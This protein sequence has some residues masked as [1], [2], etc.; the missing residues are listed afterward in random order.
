[1]WE[2][3]YGKLF[4]S[5]MIDEQIVQLRQGMIQD[6][7][8][9]DLIRDLGQVYREEVQEKQAIERI[10]KQLTRYTM[11]VQSTSEQPALP[12]GDGHEILQR[13]KREKSMRQAVKS[14]G[15]M[16]TRRFGFLA[17]VLIAT[18]LVGSVIAL[19]QVVRRGAGEAGSAPPKTNTTLATRQTYPGMY[20]RV[21]NQIIKVDLQTHNVVWR[22]TINSDSNVISISGAPIVVGKSVYFIAMNASYSL[23][24]QTGKLNWQRDFPSGAFQLYMTNGVLYVPTGDND[25]TLYVLNPADGSTKRQ[26]KA[27][28][29]LDGV[30]DGVIYLTT[31][32]KNVSML[33]AI[34]VSDGSRIWQTKFDASQSLNMV[35]MK[36]GT[37][38]ASSYH[39]KDLV[40]G[41]IPPG[42]YAY[43]IDPRN[44]RITWQSP[45]I[46][47]SIFDIAVG[48]EGQVYWRV[49]DHFV[50][51]FD[52]K[53]N[54]LIWSHA[55]TG[56]AISAPLVQNGI[57]YLGLESTSGNSSN[58][59]LVALDAATGQ[60]KWAA[61][62]NGY[63][64]GDLVPPVLKNG[65]LYVGTRKGLTGIDASNGKVLV[66]I[67]NTTLLGTND[68]LHSIIEKMVVT[69]VS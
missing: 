12:S 15:Q 9:A 2:D 43:T 53:A 17:A 68:R 8:A 32:T 66:T 31:A 28:G 19:W 48:D 45:L 55:I 14:N 42:S 27:D 69:I 18:L 60:Q 6:P 63:S 49:E 20:L 16:W 26:Y 46:Q 10:G 47:G 4:S 5:E 64:A 22:Y 3:P 39:N 41:Q 65:A 38:Y 40:S 54:K 50:A 25:G 51:A 57:M 62:L 35:Y 30:F 7:A 44:G 1:M 56:N 21:N 34:R 61:P 13:R 33:Y 59:R 23:D 37:L 52:P 29:F 36:N 67:S 11:Q 24:A 58:D